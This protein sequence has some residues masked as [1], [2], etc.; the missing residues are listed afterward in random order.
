MATY[1]AI[2]RG[3][4]ILLLCII[5]GYAYFEAHPYLMGPEIVIQEPTDGFS[6][7]TSPVIVR[8]YAHRITHIT[9]NGNPIFIDEEGTFERSVP[10]VPGY[11]VI[12]AAVTDRFGR[13]K[14]VSV[15]GLY[16]PDDTS[17][18]PPVASSTASTTVHIEDSVADDANGVDTGA[19]DVSD[20]PEERL[21]ASTT[22]DAL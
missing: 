19:S 9:L 10:L 11:A 14:T 16:T 8:G 17:Y 4:L 15:R 21:D 6:V 12:E 18:F 2:S 22:P 1:K 5:L 7:H 20:A 3:A 13:T